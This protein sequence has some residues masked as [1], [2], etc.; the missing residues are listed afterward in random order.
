M[1]GD[2][3]FMGFIPVSNLAAARDFY[4]TTLGLP[5]LE[6]SPYAVVVD[7]NGT[8]LRLTAVDD[9]RAQPFTIAGWQVD[10]IEAGVDALSTLGVTFTRYQGMDQDERGIWT[11][12]GGDRVAWFAD[13]DGNTL[14][15]TMFA[16]VGASGLSPG[17][18]SAPLTAIGSDPA[19]RPSGAGRR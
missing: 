2:A 9:L 13:L 14:S 3:S 6:A 12:P 7:A 18:M 10:D 8:M 15:L 11:T 4:G 19:T 17:C 16:A 1:L 5:V